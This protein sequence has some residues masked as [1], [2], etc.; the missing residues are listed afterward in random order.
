M[1]FNKF[2]EINRHRCESPDGFNHALHSWTLSDW[3]TAI[4]GELGEAANVAKK[5]NRIRDGIPG[6]DDSEETLR[7]KLK[8][9]IADTF[10]YL[11]LTAQAAGFTLGDVVMEVFHEK[12]RKIGYCPPPPALKWTE[13]G[14]PRRNRI[15]LDTEAESAIRNAIDA[16]ERAG[17]HPLLT[18]AVV[19]LG[20]AKDKVSDYVEREELVPG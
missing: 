16:V 11:D 17:A 4:M 7:R 18:D 9:E 6:N 20:E 15:D 14:F 1:H 19:L 5:L 3:F 10:I 2:S 13:N 8:Q 12:S